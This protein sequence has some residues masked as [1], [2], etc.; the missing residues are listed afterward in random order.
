GASFFAGSFLASGPS[1]FLPG[2][3][4]WPVARPA[5]NAA[6]RSAP[7]SGPRKRAITAVPPGCPARGAR[8]SDPADYITMRAAPRAVSPLSPPPG[9]GTP[10]APLTARLVAQH[11]PV[12]FR[13]DGTR[14][15]Q[16]EI[17]AG[18]ILLAANQARRSGGVAADEPA[19]GAGVGRQAGRDFALD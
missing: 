16:E 9:L 1:G 3:A 8:R 15:A 17:D 7:P 5:N 4:P 12:A 10:G 6:P 19:E 18:D 13:C 14:R 11:G 2:A